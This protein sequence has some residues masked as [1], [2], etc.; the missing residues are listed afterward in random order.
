[1]KMYNPRYNARYSGEDIKLPL[2]SMRKRMHS[3]QLTINNVLRGRRKDF[4]YWLF[5]KQNIQ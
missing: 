5:F 1:M 3:C 4:N 2:Q